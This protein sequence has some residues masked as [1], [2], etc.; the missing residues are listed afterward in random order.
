MYREV[1][2]VK[3]VIRNKDIIIALLSLLL[4]SFL[5]QICIASTEFTNETKIQSSDLIVNPPLADTSSPC[6]YDW[7]K[8][9]LKDLLI[10]DSRGYVWFWKNYG[11]T[12]LPVFKQ[13]TP[14]MLNSGGTLTVTSHAVPHI[15]DWDKDGDDDLIIGGNGK[16][17]FCENLASGLPQLDA[18]Q[19]ISAGGAEITHTDAVPFVYDWNG[20]YKKDLLVGE[21]EGYVYVYLNNSS[22]NT[23]AFNEGTKTIVGQEPLNVLYNAAPFVTDWNNDGRI[24]LIVGNKYGKIYAFLNTNNNENPQFGTYSLLK[25]HGVDI[26]IGNYAKPVVADWNNDYHKD[27]VVGKEDGGLALFLNS[28]TDAAPIFNDTYKIQMVSGNLVL[29]NGSTRPY[30]VDWNNDGTMDIVVGD[31]V[32]NIYVYLNASTDKDPEKWNFFAASELYMKN[33]TESIDVGN[34]ASVVVVNWN[35]DGAKDLLVGDREGK[36]TCFYNS[37]TDKWPS[38]GTGTVVLGTGSLDPGENAAPFVVDWNNDHKKDVI[39]GNKDGNILFYLNSGSDDAPRFTDVPVI[40]KAE[41]DE[42]DVVNFAVPFFYDWNEDGRNDLLIGNGAGKIYFYLNTALDG[43]SPTFY[44][45][46]QI[47]QSNETDL[48]VDNCATPFFY[49]YKDTDNACNLIT[50][51]ESGEIFF[52]EGGFSNDSPKINAVTTPTSAN[53][54]VT[55]SYTLSDPNS[56]SCNIMVIYSFNGGISWAGTATSA[57]SGDGKKNLLSTPEGRG[58]TFVWDSWADLGATQTTVQI[59]ITPNDGMIDGYFA[60]TE[61]FTVDNLATSIPYRISSTW[62]A[63]QPGNNSKPVWVNWDNDLVQRKDLIVGTELGDIYLYINTGSGDTPKFT[64]YSKIQVGTSGQTDLDVGDNAAPFVCN[65]DNDGKKDIIIGRGDGNVILYLNIGTDDNPKFTGSG[66]N[67]MAA[68]KPI[69]V[70]ANATPFL[71]DWDSDGDRDLLVGNASGYVYLFLASS[72]YPPVFGT[73]SKITKTTGEEIDVGDFATPIMGDW[74]GDGKNDLL[75]GKGGV[76]DTTS[77]IMLFIN[78]GTSTPLFKY[79]RTLEL[80]NPHKNAAPVMID[81]DGNNTQDLL[82]GTDKGYV[83]KYE[84][85]SQTLNHSPIV[86]IPSISGTQTGTVAIT[87]ILFDEDG[88]LCNITTEYSTDKGNNWSPSCYAGGDGTNSLIAIGDDPTYLWNSMADLPGTITTVIFKITA[89]DGKLTGTQTI[90]LGI[91]NKDVSPIVDGIQIHGIGEVIE[92]SCL[93]TEG[94]NE[95]SSIVVEYQGGSVGTATWRPVTMYGQTSSITGSSNVN[96]LWFSSV[97]EGGIKNSNYRIRI[98]P[99]DSNG[100]I[101]T[102][103]V[104]SPFNLDNSNTYAQLFLKGETPDW[105]TFP[106][107]RLKLK[108]SPLEDTIITIRDNIDPESLPSMETLSSLDN[109]IREFKSVKRSTPTTKVYIGAEIGIPYEDTQIGYNIERMLRIFELNG[110]C[111]EVVSGTQD[112]RMTED[113][114]VVD[115]SHFSFYRIGLYWEEGQPIVVYPNPWKAGFDTEGKVAEGGGVTFAGIC[116][117][118]KVEIFNIAGERICTHQIQP[119]EYPWIWLL[120][121]DAGQDV[122]SGIYIYLVTN[123]GHKVA[124]GK[125]AVIR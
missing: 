1:R 4:F 119:T 106:T 89:T 112:V 15:V 3:N 33:S 28:N 97:D 84:L 6:I 79:E 10:G 88:N 76:E 9:G 16:V 102:P 122:G 103:T 87:Y 42:I 110:T 80:T 34:D 108:E 115:V 71:C 18:P 52:Y 68:G 41:N 32:G 55:I 50:G 111:W 51:N 47:I 101:G 35:G 37:G 49:K 82:I 121:N 104:S 45:T 36:I 12:G 91:D 105:R 48:D 120:N 23:P 5:P 107:A 117:G 83:L 67:I 65:W 70:G 81:W 90:S 61:N 116:P 40:V 17:F 19:P 66:T 69:W 85:G 43:Q 109:T 13:G 31:F 75:V 20:D 30:S 58:Y 77:K 100:N 62:G 125:L 46:P 63:L 73:G 113:E 99:T 29:K 92:I 64:S 95:Q 118:M 93:L 124:T 24:D 86:T 26:E 54:D 123:D 96:L 21:S 57:L 14:I 59:K 11:K 60:T 98:T 44:K 114:I 94:D 27:L 72:D 78:W 74:N 7:D 8:D 39:V 25:V 2:M 22:G 53:E 38:F 56:D